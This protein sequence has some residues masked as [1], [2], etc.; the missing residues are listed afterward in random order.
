MLSLYVLKS[1][2][3]I[4][5]PKG[6]SSNSLFTL[7]F[8]LCSFAVPLSAQKTVIGTW[9]AV[10]DATNDV[11]AHVQIFEFQGK[12]YGKVIKMVKL[13]AEQR[14]SLCPGDLKDQPIL[15][16]LILEKLQLRDGFY[17]N[18]KMLDIQSGKWYSCQMW[19]KDEDPDVLVIRTFLGFIYRTQHWYRV[20]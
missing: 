18:G 3:S 15:G 17:K 2:P 14:C 10:D 4:F 19:L 11:R 5:V 9:K 7:L 12:I 20:N 1:L 16:M 13:D 8:I 6:Y